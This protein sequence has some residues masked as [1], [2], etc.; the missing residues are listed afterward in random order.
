AE[1]D[2]VQEGS[3]SEGE[4][5]QSIPKTRLQRRSR[6]RPPPTGAR[7][8]LKDGH[9]LAMATM[10]FRPSAIRAG[11]C[12]WLAAILSAVVSAQSQPISPDSTPIAAAAN[13]ESSGQ[14]ATLVFFNRP[15]L[16]LRARVFG[17]SPQ[18]RVES[19]LETLNV[20]IAQRTTGPVEV[21]RLD[22]GDLIVVGPRG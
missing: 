12:V 16:E 21:R 1:A 6:A 17:R 5:S 9:S 2:S 11:Y 15:I 10:A 8:L 20:L 19:A 14:P 22:A 7:R 3:P 4:T 18:D 13:P